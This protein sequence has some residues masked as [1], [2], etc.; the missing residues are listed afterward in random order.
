LIGDVAVTEES[1]PVSGTERFK[2]AS[3]EAPAAPDRN[4]I[5]LAGAALD[6]ATGDSQAASMTESTSSEQP[7]LGTFPI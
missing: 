2:G 3:D 7:A 1:R 5:E 4:E 6:T